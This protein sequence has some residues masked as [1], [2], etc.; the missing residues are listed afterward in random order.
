MSTGRTSA[1]S[2][3]RQPRSSHGDWG[4][5]SGIQPLCWFAALPRALPTG[6]LALA[7]APAAES[8]AAAGPPR[9][10]KHARPPSRSTPAAPQACHAF[11][12]KKLT[13]AASNDAARFF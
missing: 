13:P 10:K 11:C 7:F 6:S 4:T 5:R 1:M 3:F 8:V 12:T 9:P 2:R